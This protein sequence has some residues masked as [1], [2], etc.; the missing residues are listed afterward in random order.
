MSE[1]PRQMAFATKFLNSVMLDGRSGINAESIIIVHVRP[2]Y[3][4]SH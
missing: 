1:I 3:F 2:V 4:V